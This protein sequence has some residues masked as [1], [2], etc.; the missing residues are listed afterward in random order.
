M[1]QVTFLD[2]LPAGVLGQAYERQ[3]RAIDYTS[4]VTK[5]NVALKGTRGIASKP[6]KT[7]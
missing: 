6:S 1:F 4:P 3:I 5:I 7:Q 2:L